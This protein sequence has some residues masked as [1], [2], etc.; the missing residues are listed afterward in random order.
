MVVLSVGFSWLTVLRVE[1]EPIILILLT[2]IGGE[3]DLLSRRFFYCVLIILTENKYIKY[4]MV[5]MK[6]AACL[7]MV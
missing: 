5:L 2:F 4:F 1:I 3:N 6:L 7:T